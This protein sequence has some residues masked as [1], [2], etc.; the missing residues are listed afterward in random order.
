MSNPA[1]MK[2]KDWARSLVIFFSVPANVLSVLAILAVV[3]VPAIEKWLKAEDDLSARTASLVDATNELIQLG[4][5]AQDPATASASQAQVVFAQREIQLNRATALAKSIGDR[6]YPS[7][8]FALAPL[9]CRDGRNADADY[10]LKRVVQRSK[11]WNSD[12][13]PSR[14]ELAQAHVG[15]ARC[16]VIGA[17]AG[18]PLSKQQQRDVDEHMTQALHLYAGDAGLKAQGEQ[19]NINGEWAEMDR[20]LGDE[21]GAATHQHSADALV[22]AVRQRFPQFPTF[23]RAED[24]R[25]PLREGDLPKAPAGLVYAVT[26]PGRAELLERVFMQAGK[27]GPDFTGNA[28]MFRYEK[29]SF[30]GESAVAESVIPSPAVTVLRWDTELPATVD[31]KRKPHVAM[32][33]I[34]EKSSP[35]LLEGVQQAVGSPPMRFVAVRLQQSP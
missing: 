14:D 10:F 30:V 21:H 26:F 9:L 8:L 20:Q 22:A 29:G 5:P 2:I 12:R 32:E 23:R 19:A 3:I 24:K 17:V 33:W 25:D 11:A 4:D 6:T 18:R 13:R 28:T 7:V 16:L 34:I 15:M 1:A 35:D 31:E 27:T